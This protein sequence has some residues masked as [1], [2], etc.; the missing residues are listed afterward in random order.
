[1]K[2]KKKNWEYIS[3]LN[4]LLLERGFMKKLIALIKKTF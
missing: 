4:V 1:M 3:M 2:T